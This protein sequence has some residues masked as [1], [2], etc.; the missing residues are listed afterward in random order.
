MKDVLVFVSGM[1]QDYFGAFWERVDEVRHEDLNI[2]FT[3]TTGTDLDVKQHIDRLS[4]VH[5]KVESSDTKGPRKTKERDRYCDDLP[6]EWTNRHGDTGSLFGNQNYIN[7]FVPGDDDHIWMFKINR[8]D[9]QSWAERHLSTT[10]E[11]YYTLK[12]VGRNSKLMWMPLE[13]LTAPD[14]DI[15]YKK[16]DADEWVLKVYRQ[17]LENGITCLDRLIAKKK[18]LLPS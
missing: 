17:V 16:Y 9:L 18:S 8:K 12:S 10:N 11:H 6:L 2:P 15:E 3:S 5:G 7:Q 13:D 14:T 1:T 4:Y